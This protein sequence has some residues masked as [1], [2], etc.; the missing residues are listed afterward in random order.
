MPVVEGLEVAVVADRGPG[1]LDQD[2]LEMLV[3][4]A[5]PAGTAFPRGFVVARADPGPGGQVGG[6]REVPADVRSGLG[7]DRGG[8][9]RIAVLAADTG[10]DR[11]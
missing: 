9:A 10:G 11:E 5:A 3:A 8:R 7:D 4:M 2:W 1:C 6:V